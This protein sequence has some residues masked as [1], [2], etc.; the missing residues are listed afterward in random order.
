MLIKITIFKIQK[1]QNKIK[2]NI[3]LVILPKVKEPFQK[4][5]IDDLYIEGTS[6]FLFT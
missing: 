1:P 6:I 4:Q 3:N 2:E 5:L